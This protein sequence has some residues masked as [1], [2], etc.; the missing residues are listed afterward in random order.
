M[1]R[2]AEPKTVSSAASWGALF[3]GWSDFTATRDAYALRIDFSWKPEM[4]TA[5][6]DAAFGTRF[7]AADAPRYDLALVGKGLHDAAFRPAPLPA[8]VDRRAPRGPLPPPRGRVGP[9][10]P[11]PPAWRSR[12]VKLFSMTSSKQVSVFFR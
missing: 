5:D 11:A 2:H 1:R 10:R 8:F 7:C 9:L 12:T 3:L 6:D 4:H